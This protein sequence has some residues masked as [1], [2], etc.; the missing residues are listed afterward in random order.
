MLGEL[1]S[2]LGCSSSHLLRMNDNELLATVSNRV[3]GDF[4]EARTIDLDSWLMSETEVLICA[5]IASPNKTSM[6]ER[7]T[8]E[9]WQTGRLN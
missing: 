5:L 3:M 9:Q 2:L 4:D 6:I 7:Q 1:K 8:T